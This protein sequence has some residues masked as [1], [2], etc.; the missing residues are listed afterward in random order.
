MVKEQFDNLVN[1]IKKDNQL[2]SIPLCCAEPDGK[3]LVL[4]GNHRLKAYE[5]AGGEYAFVLVAENLTE[6]EKTSIQI[7]HNAITG[8]DDLSILKQIYESIKEIEHKVYSGLTSN[9]LKELQEIKF[10]NPVEP[11]IDFETVN[12]LF[13]P[14]E[15]KTI[16]NNFQEFKDAFLGDIRNQ[17]SNAAKIYLITHQIFEKYLSLIQQIKKKERIINHAVAF[18]VMLDLAQQ[19]WEEI[20]TNETEQP[21]QVHSTDKG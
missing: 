8:Q 12:L 16:E 14:E 17:S 20:Q 1:N 5:K 19:K 15:I 10:Q 13:L 4:S 6:D 9:Q 7:S 18:M 2:A 21:N 11:R 3:Y